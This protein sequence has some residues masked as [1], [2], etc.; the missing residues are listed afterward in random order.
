MHHDYNGSYADCPKCKLLLS[1]DV[2]PALLDR[3]HRLK[4]AKKA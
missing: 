3:L 2:P 1:E 4:R